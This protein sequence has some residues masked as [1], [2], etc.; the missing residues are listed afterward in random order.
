MK[1]RSVTN[2]H[3]ESSENQTNRNKGLKSLFKMVS[4]T[5]QL[6]HFY[7]QRVFQKCS[8]LRQEKNPDEKGR[9]FSKKLLLQNWKAFDRLLCLIQYIFATKPANFLIKSF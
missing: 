7:Q 2:R 1:H 4:H 3:M 9:R 6:G 5:E 8:P